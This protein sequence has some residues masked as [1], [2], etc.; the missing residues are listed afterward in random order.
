[1]KTYVHSNKHNLYVKRGIERFSRIYCCNTLNIDKY[2]L[3]K[4][5]WTSPTFR[6]AHYVC[7]STH[8]EVNTENHGR[9]WKEII[10]LLSCNKS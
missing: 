5:Y 4:G 8:L 6:V 7:L 10:G 1:M 2:R 9:L 3:M